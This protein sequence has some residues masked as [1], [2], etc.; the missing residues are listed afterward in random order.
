MEAPERSRD[1]PGWPGYR[2]DLDGCIWSCRSWNKLTNNWKKLRPGKVGKYYSVA[3][4]R[5]AGT[6]PTS[7]YV[8]HAVLLAFIGPWPDG[9]EAI[10]LN[11]IQT[12]N[13]PENLAWGTHKRNCELRRTN[14][15]D[16]LGEQRKNSKLKEAQVRW[17][18]SNRHLYD[19]F[20][21]AK[22]CGVAPGTVRDILQGRTWRH[23]KI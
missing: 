12:D 5:G 4:C 6:R 16:K 8:H 1:I 7:I 20:E 13:R 15:K 3:L 14:G 2:A 11:D 22:Q 9:M 23:V 17:I 10:H 19:R 21:M 18:L